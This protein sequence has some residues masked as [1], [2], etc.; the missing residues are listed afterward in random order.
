M[1]ALGDRPVGEETGELAE[2]LDDARRLFGAHLY[3][4]V[5]ELLEPR[6]ATAAGD[7]REALQGL[8][9]VAVGFQHLANGNTTG[10]RALL[11][12]G[13]ARLHGRVLGA[14]ALDGFA[15]A[16]LDAAGAVPHRDWLRVP[17][18]PRAA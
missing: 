18:F 4:E 12:D 9:Q 5:H 3:F 15:R 1:A 13:A 7:E 14:L 8:I 16:V 10:A 11:V 6:W 17:A 2:A